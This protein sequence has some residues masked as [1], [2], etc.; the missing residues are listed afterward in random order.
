MI[1]FTPKQNQIT[2]K[3]K[4]ES[5]FRYSPSN[6]TMKFVMGYAAALRVITTKQIGQT[7]VLLN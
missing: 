4:Q 5:T 7:S 3:A 1:K 6:L 2:H